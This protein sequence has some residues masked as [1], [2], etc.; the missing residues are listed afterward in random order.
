MEVVVIAV[1]AMATYLTRLLPLLLKE[2]IDFER[3]GNFLSSSSTAVISS[4]FLT[5]FLSVQRNLPVGLVSLGVVTL[6]FLKWRNLGLSVIS[7]VV[8]YFFISQAIS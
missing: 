8:A 2:K 5:S 6:T 7:G 1:V 3:W 4:L